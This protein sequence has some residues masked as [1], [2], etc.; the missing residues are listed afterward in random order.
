M[1]LSSTWFAG[2]RQGLPTDLAQSYAYQL[3]SALR[4]LH[5][6][7]RVVHRDVKLE[8]CLLEYEPSDPDGPGLLRMCDFGMAE[9]LSRDESF[10]GNT[11]G[12]PSPMVN[13]TDRPP[14]KPFGPADTSTSAFT[15]GSLEYAAPE[16]LRI[17]KAQSNA[18]EQGIEDVTISP[19]R[20]IVSPAVDLWAYGVC[21]FSLIV[22]SRPFQNSFQPRVLMAILAGAWDRDQLQG[23]GGEEVSE[24]VQG[25][26]EMEEEDRWDIQRVLRS[27]WFEGMSDRWEDTKENA[28]GWK[29]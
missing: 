24:L 1:A 3:A 5:L 17:A 18:S 16:I 14:Q 25:C 27:E 8:N 9:W 22:G 19:E 2:N 15:G 21:V 10:G 12:P 23:K 20:A 26:L 7:A 11:S 6:D 29:L 13:E 4:Y 28:T